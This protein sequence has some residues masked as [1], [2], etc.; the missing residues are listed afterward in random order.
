M[1]FAQLKN[2]V[3][4][5]V[6]NYGVQHD[7]IEN[8]SYV[9]NLNLDFTKKQKRVLLAYLNYNDASDSLK[10]GTTHTNQPRLF[11]ILTC[12]YRLGMV[13]DTCWSLDTKAWERLK[14]T[15]YD[16]I[17]GFGPIFQLACQANTDA[18]KIIYMTEDPYF[19]ADA[20]EK[21]RV[22]YFNQRHY[23]KTT[24]T[25]LDKFINTRAG[26]F[27]PE[28][29][30]EVA[31]YIVCQGNP[32]HFSHLSKKIYV[33]VPNAFRNPDFD[34][35]Q[36]EKDDYSFV[37]FGASSLIRKGTDILVETF[38]KH[39]DWKLYLCDKNIT[40]NLNQ[41]G[42]NRLPSNIYDVGFVDINSN[43]LVELF[44]QIRYIVLPSCTEAPSS[45]VLTGMRHGLI[46]I[47]TRGIGLDQFDDFCY[48]FDDFHI[49]AVEDTIKECLKHTRQEL[50]DRSQSL[51]EYANTHFTLEEFT[52]RMFDILNE[53]CS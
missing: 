52:S 29:N 33:I 24:K 7:I 47:V 4:R 39:P 11:Q 30:E 10:K 15:K 18:K 6:Y 14:T 44:H 17:F 9:T 45:A 36:S 22:N 38:Q 50:E 8:R 49:E 53:I 35:D 3:I 32:S 1:N 40:H 37:M 21:E 31:D 19:V 51:F 25:G 26:V 16:I 46:P 43:R 2:K 13:V 48:Y 20:R 28:G 27:Y 12:F 23:N 5:R 42:Y 34:N 41:L